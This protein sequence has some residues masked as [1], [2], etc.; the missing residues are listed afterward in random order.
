[1]VAQFYGVRQ[2]AKLLSVAPPQ[3]SYVL[4]HEFDERD[5]PM[6]AGRRA[7]PEAMV[8]RVAERLRARGVPVNEG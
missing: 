1:M 8:P 7:V 4:Y 6:I 3:I 5:V 2:L